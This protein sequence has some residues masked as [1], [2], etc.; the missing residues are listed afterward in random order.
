MLIVLVCKNEIMAGLAK[1]TEL[2]HIIK[3]PASLL[4]LAP[5]NV[6]H[7]LVYMRVCMG[8][9]M[10]MYVCVCD[11][12]L[13]IEHQSMK[14]CVCACVCGGYVVDMNFHLT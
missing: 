10:C 11:S 12:P 9:C 5:H 8:E 6:L 4:R 1:L 13:L 14:I 2:D 3:Y 7:L